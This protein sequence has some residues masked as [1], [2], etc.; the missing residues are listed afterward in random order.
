LNESGVRALI[1]VK[2]QRQWRRGSG[3]RGEAEWPERRRRRWS[4]L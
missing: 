4:K 1:Y 2:W 3:M